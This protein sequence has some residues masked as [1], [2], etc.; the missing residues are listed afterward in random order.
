MKRNARGFAVYTEFADTCGA[1]VSVHQSSVAGVRR[2]WVTASGGST[3]GDKQ[4]QMHENAKAIGFRMP[5][6]D[7]VNDNTAAHL[8]PAQARRL[9]KALL[10]FAN[11]GDR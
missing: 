4:R 8:T 11:G 10:R 7:I 9:A 2:C 5:G 6:Q 3:L 1:S